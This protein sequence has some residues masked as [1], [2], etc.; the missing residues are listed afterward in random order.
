M[1]MEEAKSTYEADKKEA[2]TKIIGGIV[3]VTTGV[4]AVAG[5]AIKGLSK[6]VKGVSKAVTKAIII[7]NKVLANAQIVNQVAKAGVNTA[8]SILRFQVADERYR[9]SL[10]SANAKLSQEVF[11][12]NLKQAKDMQEAYNTSKRNVDEII[13]NIRSFLHRKY[14][15]TTSV[16]RNI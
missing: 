15:T 9:A 16:T 7:A 8:T 13:D 11:E 2:W 14:E 6:A 5:S 12:F 3:G 1:K 10:L 4:L